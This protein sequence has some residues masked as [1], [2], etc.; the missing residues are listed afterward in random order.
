MNAAELFSHWEPVRRGLFE[1]LD[2][3]SD[4][5]LAFVPRE[6][7]WSLGTVARHIAN[8]EDGWFG[9]VAIGELDE[10]PSLVEEDCATVESVKKL[11]AE[12]HK[13]TRAYL[14]TVDAEDLDRVIRTPWGEELP[15]RWI[16]WHVIEHEIHHRGEIFMMLGLMGMEAPEI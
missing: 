5:Q 10:W 8:A 7:L 12:V 3:V 9:Y 15:L 16:V 14:A 2:K 4:E 11:L 1:A 6:G 13:R